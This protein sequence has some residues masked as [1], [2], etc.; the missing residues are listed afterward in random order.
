MSIRPA[1]LTV[2]T[3]LHWTATAVAALGS[4]GAFAGTPPPLHTE[5]Q[6]SVSGLSS[7]AAMAVQIGVADADRVSGVGIVA[8]PPY[9]CAQGFVTKAVNDCLKIGSTELQKMLGPWF[10]PIFASSEKDIDVP[11]LIT[12]TERMARDGRI[13]PIADLAHQRVWE[14]RGD[15]DAV[16]GVKA[17]AAQRLYY[18]HFGAH[19]ERGQPAD[20]HI[21]H[22]MPTDDP[23]QGVCQTGD[24]DYVSDCHFDAAGALLKSLRDRPQALP[25]EADGQWYTLD[26][27]TFIPDLGHVTARAEKR[28]MLGLAASA[29]VYVPPVCAT[30]NCQVHVVLHGCQQGIDQHIYDNFVEHA[31]Y[32]RW[33]APL[34]LVLL[35]PRVEAIK[36]YARGAW[37]NVANP[38]GCWDWWGY[39]T[40]TDLHAYAGK[41]APQIRTIVNMVDYL[42]RS[43]R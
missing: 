38:N 16:V 35:F 20:G 18:E 22:T 39:T 24:K 25:G 5:A 1:Y 41:N 37:D 7:G 26:Q 9:L 15:D 11:D 17:S 10:G 29:R 31:G 21:P 36:P 23:S 28:R 40:P 6:F 33:A 42:G 43:G 32:L 19:F 34:R 27:A 30:A 2:R 3:I 14:Y 4:A 12:D 13:A 8:G